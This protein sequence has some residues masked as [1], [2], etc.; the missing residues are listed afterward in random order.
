MNK[1][2]PSKRQVF[3]AVLLSLF[4]VS[5]STLGYY[6]GRSSVPA[7]VTYYLDIPSGIASYYIRKFSNGS[8][9]MVNGE[10]WQCTAQSTSS[11]LIINWAIGNTSEGKLFITEGEYLCDTT[12]NLVHGITIEGEGDSTILKQADGADLWSLIYANLNSANSFGRYQLKNF[13]ID[14]NK[15]NQNGPYGFGYGIYSDTYSSVYHDYVTLKDLHIKNTYGSGVH[16]NGNW[17]YME[18]VRVDNAGGNGFEI[19]DY[20]MKAVGCGSYNAEWNGFYLQGTGLHLLLGCTARSNGYCG[21]NMTGEGIFQGLVRNQIIGGEVI[22]NGRHG[23]LCH[24]VKMCAATQVF[25]SRNGNNGSF[26]NIHFE[27]H[28]SVHSQNNIINGCTFR[29]NNK[30]GYHVREANSNQNFNLIMGSNIYD[31]AMTA[32][33]SLQG[34]NS[35]AVNTM[36]PR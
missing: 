15:D 8:T 34:A 21:I 26:N 1:H 6:I 7:S 31:D 19:D 29:S 11:S 13:V 17:H 27:S 25:F 35:T 14:G 20:R 22:S 18:N 3:Y 12:I 9:Y 32:N 5:S 4:L 2:L 36:G 16:T 30:S 28:S 33:I 24:G 23:I 10:T